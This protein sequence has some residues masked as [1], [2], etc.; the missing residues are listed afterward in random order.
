MKFN[1]I[2]SLAKINLSLNIIKRLPNRYH[3]IESLVTFVKIFDE[4]KIRT[5]KNAHHKI[6]FT[7]N[8]AKGI[9]NNN[10]VSKLLK[11]L[12]EKKLIKNKKFEIKIKKNIPQKSGM[13]GGSMNAAAIIKYFTK[14]K[15][16]NISKNKIHKLAYAIGADVILGLEKKN[17]IAF[18]NGKIGRLNKK[19]NL[20]VLIVKPNIDYSTKYIYAKV[21]KYSKSIY[22]NKN[23]LFFTTRNLINSNNALENVV[24]KKYPKINNLKYFLSKLPKITFVRMTGSGS[25]IVAY[26]KSK[27]AAKKAAKLFRR[28]YKNYWY[29]VSKTI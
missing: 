18:V 14:K 29:I 25:A 3:K 28:K 5:I 12:E 2:N 27:R 26:F 20:H 8:F 21:K 24:F 10:T 7:G 17:S 4:I 13:G 16:V 22:T 23:K 9:G 1:K 19:I 15:I 11:L 6:S